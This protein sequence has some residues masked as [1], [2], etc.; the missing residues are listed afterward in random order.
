MEKYEP[1]QTLM[2][3][4]WIVR[5][6]YLKQ[7]KSD[8]EQKEER[9]SIPNEVVN[10]YLVALQALECKGKTE[11]KFIDD[12]PWQVNCMAKSMDGAQYE[13]L[14]DICQD[15]DGVYYFKFKRMGG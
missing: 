6:N 5:P 11:V 1:R 3:G 7:A 10:S 8:E 9:N 13:I 12:N 15:E 2:T 14:M 4:R